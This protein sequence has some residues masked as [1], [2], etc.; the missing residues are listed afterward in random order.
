[1]QSA[2]EPTTDFIKKK[3][4]TKKRKGG[5]PA[6]TTD[7]HAHHTVMENNI[8]RDLYSDNDMELDDDADEHVGME[9]DQEQ[10]HESGRSGESDSQSDSDSDSDSSY[11]STGDLLDTMALLVIL[12]AL[13]AEERKQRRRAFRGHLGRADLLHPR[14]MTPWRREAVRERN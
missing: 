4:Y 8:D 14:S 1:M 10:D 9:D 11:D 12:S 13:G 7:T 2:S 6:T 5:R 3:L